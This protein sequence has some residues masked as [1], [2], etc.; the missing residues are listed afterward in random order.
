[1]GCLNSNSEPTV[2]ENYVQDIKVDDQNVE[3]S[4]WDTAGKLVDC[5]TQRGGPTCMRGQEDFDRL[6][7]L[8]YAETHVIMLCFSVRTHSS[9]SH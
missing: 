4:L 2:F 8:S 5:D 1:M 3:M 6:R 7:S 9:N